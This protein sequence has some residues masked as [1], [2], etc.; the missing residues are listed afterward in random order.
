[1]EKK[2]TLKT[3]VYTKKS[4]LETYVRRYRFAFNGKE[5]DDE[6]YGA[7][8]EY[9]FGARI[10]NPR[11]GVWLA[12]DPL[13]K[14]YPS[15]S[16]YVYTADNPIMY[17]DPDGQIIMIPN[18]ADR[19][20]VLK[21]INSR[22]R[23]TFG[24]NDK[25]ELYLIKAE[26]KNG[27][28]EYYR[29]RLVSAM[30]DGGTL[31]IHMQ[32]KV[33]GLQRVDYRTRKEVDKKGSIDLVKAGGISV[34]T[35]EGSQQDVYISGKDYNTLGSENTNNVKDASGNALP[36]EA[37]DILIHETVGHGIPKLLK[38]AKDK[39]AVTEE[40]KVRA[41]LKPGHNTQRKDDPKHKASSGT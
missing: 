22:A 21:M 32:D 41:Q 29:D 12:L 9:D 10:Y 28:S 11:L 5:H 14:N 19:E 7:G 6:T 13:M 15:L 27:Y 31:S 39:N 16:A 20:P 37:A 4:G 35:T 25:G 30:T 38:D 1:M 33:D 3:I 23:G 24:I 17:I 18:V 26:G 36:Q 2:Q 8:N 40:N 34:P